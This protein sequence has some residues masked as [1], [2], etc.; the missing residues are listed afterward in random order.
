MKAL[1]IIVCFFASLTCSAVDEDMLNQFLNAIP[2]SVVAPRRIGGETVEHN[3]TPWELSISGSGAG[4]VA[5]FSAVVTLSRD[6]NG[7]N[8]L[9][10]GGFHER[11]G[12]LYPT[13]GFINQTRPGHVQDGEWDFGYDSGVAT[14]TWTKG[15]AT[16]PL[17][18]MLEGCEALN[19]S[20]A[21][22][23]LG[24][25]PRKALSLIRRQQATLAAAKALA[26]VEEELR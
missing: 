1:L 10:S 14:W 23:V 3:H 22:V 21:R 2:D 20:I 25:N 18:A 6:D 12:V 9:L 17:P 4:V 5:S 24:K 16:S 7:Q 19:R 13:P 26:E 8:P 11:Y 15:E